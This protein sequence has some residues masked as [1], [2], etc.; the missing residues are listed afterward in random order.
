VE[1]LSQKDVCVAPV[2]DVDEM[3]RD[4]HLVARR[5]IV[6]SEHPTAGRIR[7]VGSMFKLSDSPVEVRNWAT[8]HSQHTDEVLRELGYDEARISELRDADVIG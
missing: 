2:Y 3:D 4:P 5:M 7:Q 6:E 8:S 1:L